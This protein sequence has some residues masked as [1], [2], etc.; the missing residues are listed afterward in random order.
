MVEPTSPVPVNV[1]VVMLVRLSPRTP[2][3]DAG[4]STATGGAAGAVVS[5][6]RFSGT[7]AADTFAAGSVEVVVMM[8]TPSAN[9]AEVKDQVPPADTS[10]VPSRVAPS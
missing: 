6:M 1:G 10:A 7:D 2:L 3:S 5:M 9:G 4:A 8:C